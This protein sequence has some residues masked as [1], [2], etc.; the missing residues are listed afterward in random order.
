MD[1]LLTNVAGVV[2]TLRT[3]S[4]TLQWSRCVVKL[5][6]IGGLVCDRWNHRLWL[7]VVGENDGVTTCHRPT[8]YRTRQLSYQNV[9]FKRS[10]IPP[11]FWL[12]RRWTMTLSV[13]VFS[14]H[15]SHGLKFTQAVLKECEP[16]SMRMLLPS[17]LE[18]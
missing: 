3:Q 10:K 5:E 14:G 1:W 2:Y 11:Y 13:S 15:E 12:S 9:T 18:F 17:L 4:W 8:Y 7:F 16:T 6:L